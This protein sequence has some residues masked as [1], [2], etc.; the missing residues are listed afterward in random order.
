MRIGFDA[1]K[2]LNPRDGIGRYAREL[3]RAL[4]ELDAGVELELFGLPDAAG[5]AAAREQLWGLPAT[6]GWRTLPGTID[7]FHSTAWSV[8]PGFGGPLVFTCHDLTFLTLPACHTLDNKVH[9]LTGLLRA[10][11][12][13]AHFL[14]VSRATAASLD[15]QVG[16]G[17]ERVDVIHHGISL[18]IQPLARREA[19]RRLRER[20]QIEGAPVL[21]VGTLEP[22]KNL[23]RL[24]DAYAG[25]DEELR[26]AHP[27]IIAGA[28][29]W[30]NETL[31]ARCAEIG[32]DRLR[33]S[34]ATV[35]R[36]DPEGDEDL[37]LLYSAAAVFAYPSLAE[38][39][40]LPVVEAMACG[41]PVITSNTSSLPEVAGDAAWLIDPLDTGDIRDALEELLGNPDHRRRLRALGRKRAASFSWA[42]T[43]RRTLDLYR[44]LAERG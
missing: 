22:R 3:L 33:A 25:L 1:S 19:R 4:L 26:Q 18:D 20:W 34:G 30:K 37:A 21:A 13:G 15:Q 16:I 8:P 9:C 44:R 41:A 42:E 40:G 6:S 2:A 11:L 12:A 5:E 32:N 38:G 14:A 31:L 28:G 35:H 43:A 36:L 10:N 39:F 29:G 17:A 27:L 7:V 24:I 23:V